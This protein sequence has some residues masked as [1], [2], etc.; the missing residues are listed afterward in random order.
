M[1]FKMEYFAHLVAKRKRQNT[2]RFPPVEATVLDP[3][4]DARPD[5]RRP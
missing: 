3:V 2:L 1:L 4:L 5:A